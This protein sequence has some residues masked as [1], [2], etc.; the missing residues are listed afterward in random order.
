MG[1]KETSGPNAHLLKLT[2]IFKAKEPWWRQAPGSSS[3]V[4]EVCLLEIIF[5]KVDVL[6]SKA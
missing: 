4:A 2:K 6:A 3:T 1:R 5:F